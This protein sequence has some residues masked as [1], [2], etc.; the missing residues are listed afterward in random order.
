[1]EEPNF[2]LKDLIWILRRWAWLLVFGILF[3]SGLSLLINISIAPVYQATTK[4]LITRTGQFQLSDYTAQLSNLQ[5]TQTYL[6]LLSTKT[7]LDI[8]SE[9]TGIQIE[10]EDIKTQ[11]IKDTQIIQIDIENS[12]PNQAA[13]IANSMVEVLIEQNEVIQSGRY[14]SMEESLRLQKTQIEEEIQNIQRQIEQV[15]TQS[16][17]QQKSWIEMQIS[18]LQEE[19]D[20]LQQ[21]IEEMGVVISLDERQLFDQK[22]ARLDQVQSLLSLYQENYNDLLL[23]YG[24]PAQ[25]TID[26]T[27]SQLTLLTTTQALYQQFYA[28]VLKDLGTARLARMQNTP[29][30][31]QIE[32]ASAPEDPIRPRILVNTI[33]G[34]LAGFVLIAGIALLRETLDDTLKTPEDVERALGMPVIGFVAEMKHKKNNAR[35]LLIANQPRSP[36]SDAFRSIHA[37][38]ELASVQNP[39]HTILVT[40][41]GTSEGKST[42]AVNLAAIISQTGKRVALLDAD[43]RHPQ[44]HILLGL[45]NDA[46]I[47]NLFGNHAEIQTVSQTR[48]DL[49]DLMIIT[50][51]SLPPN[52]VE[53]LGSDKLRQILNGLQSL[54]DLVVIDSPPS[55]IAD[56]QILVSKVDAVLFVIQPGHTHIKAA[57]NSTELFKR[58][59]ARIVGVVMN[60]IPRDRNYYY[61]S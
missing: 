54:V 39:I 56:T 22:S 25:S 13:L 2:D 37:N 45:P 33:F 24:S 55:F 61:S 52:S 60:R 32:I 41:P 1:M 26:I 51:G 18:S 9:R 4:V 21:E 43:L 49:P 20:R 50:S 10:P 34:A 48:P 35:D 28:T 11:V 3:G 38:L 16:L 58:A 40:S 53:L 29:D 8:V 30:V 6:Q 27:N 46:G 14:N 44:I 47:S 59:G 36:S 5:L 7:V 23:T 31:I 12:D 42:I 15:S 19:E 57:Q 17:E